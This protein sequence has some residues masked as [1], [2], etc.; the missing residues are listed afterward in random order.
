[1]W[2]VETFGLNSISVDQIINFFYFLVAVVGATSLILLFGEVTPKIYA[3]L[4]NRKLALWMAIP[5]RFVDIILK[6][7]TFVLVGMTNK[8][9]K[10]LLERRVGMNTS[11]KEELD[12]AIDLAVSQDIGS[13]RQVDMLKELSNLMMFQQLK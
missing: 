1:M 9:E 7:L 2:C 3:Q 8:V 12:A 13:L 11:S 6:P 4:N 10:R 5:L